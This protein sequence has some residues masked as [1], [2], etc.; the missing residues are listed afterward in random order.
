MNPA[1]ARVSALC[2][3]ACIWI[4]P[5]MLASPTVAQ[6]APGFP[7]QN[8]MP[9]IQIDPSAMSGRLQEEMQKCTGLEADAGPY[10]T[11][12]CKM[13][14]GIV[15]IAMGQHDA[16]F[17]T[18]RESASILEGEG[19]RFGSAVVYLM[20]GQTA[21]QAGRSDDA[22]TA[23]EKSISTLEEARESG[24]P[25]VLKFFAF[26]VRLSGV[27][28]PMPTDGPMAQMMG[29]MMLDQ[30]EL[31]VRTSLAPQ[32][33]AMGRLEEAKAQL[34]AALSVSRRHFGMMDGPVLGLL[35]Q[36]RERQGRIAEAIEMYDQ[37]IAA[38]RRVQNGS[39]Q[40]QLEA[41]RNALLEKANTPS[42]APPKQA[43]PDP[44]ASGGRVGLL[45]Q[46]QLPSG[47]EGLL[48]LDPN[49]VDEILVREGAR[50]GIARAPPD[51]GEC[52]LL[53]G[54]AKVGAG[55]LGSG[56]LDLQ[57]SVE[58]LDQA[59]DR[60]GSILIRSIIGSTQS[61][62]NVHAEA[63]AVYQEAISDLEALVASDE[64]LGLG[65]LTAFLRFAG[66]PEAAFPD[67]ANPRGR[68]ILLALVELV[69]RDGFSMVLARQ[70]RLEDAE[71]EIEKAAAMAASFS[72]LMDSQVYD[73]Y[74]QIVALRGRFEDARRHYTRALDG[75]SLFG[76]VE[77]RFEILRRLTELERVRGRPDEAIRFNQQALDLAMQRDRKEHVALAWVD[78]TNI[79]FDDGSMTDARSAARK[80]VEAAS[81][82]GN[83]MAR[84]QAQLAEALVATAV[85]DY[86]DALGHFE[87]TL[88]ILRG[89]DTDLPEI[90]L[91]EVVTL[92]LTGAVYG[93]LGRH[94]MI[95]EKADESRK[96]AEASGHEQAIAWSGLLQELG[97]RM[98][99]EPD[100]L[101]EGVQWHLDNLSR[102]SG[103]MHR[104]LADK[105]NLIA[106]LADLTELDARSLTAAR[107]WLDQQDGTEMPWER[108]VPVML[109]AAGELSR[110]RSSEAF[111]LLQNLADESSRSGMVELQ[112]M[113][114]S[115][116]AL[117]QW[118][119]GHPEAAATTA[120]ESAELLDQMAEN[121]QVYELL[122]AL[123]GEGRQ[124]FY[125]TAVSL[126][127]LN[128]QEEEAFLMAERAR[129]R[130]LLHM[131]DKQRFN[132]P[133][134][135]DGDLVEELEALRREILALERSSAPDQLLN[136]K[137][138]RYEE[139][140]V[141]I[142]LDAP[143]LAGLRSTWSVSLEIVQQDLLPPQ[144]TLLSFFLARHSVVAWVVDRDSLT[145]VVLPVSD[146]DL[147]KLSCLA[148]QVS[149]RPRGAT[150]VEPGCR[151]EEP[152][153]QSFFSKLLAPLMDEV[154]HEQLIV[155]PHGIL[156]YVP[157]AA[158]QNPETGQYL[159]ETHTVS[160]VP[161][162]GLLAI[163]A[164]KKSPFSG[165][166][167][168]MG[169]PGSDLKFVPEEVTGI[170]DLLGVKPF[171]REE[172]S[173]DRVFAAAGKIDLLHLA[174]HGRYVP[175]APRFSH[176]ALHPDGDDDGR[177]EVDEIFNSLDL[178]GVDLVALSACQTA[179][180]EQNDGDEIISLARAFIYAG[181]PAVVSTLWRV[182]DEA[183][184]FLMR[185]F[186]EHLISGQSYSE[187]LRTAQQDTLSHP[188]Q[189]EWSAPYYWA[190]FTLTG[191]GGGRWERS[192]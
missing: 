111:A 142:K 8:G 135:I 50:C 23:F 100:T 25:V 187:A 55:R 108:A 104:K 126:M 94:E 170:A 96:I 27:D 19:D 1:I 110:G 137:K 65:I 48:D 182:N 18:F 189:P 44:P 71:R 166:A 148:R 145:Q 156:H 149:R 146:E 153:A 52:R 60:V 9:Q 147:E 15:T 165:R 102:S 17:A 46:F 16:G 40:T 106:S 136:G 155:V 159:L 158:L 13:L 43:E 58:A 66:I 192:P 47:P 152:L 129:S 69:V 105:K 54:L 72:G 3:S 180:G 41:Q 42:A 64:V 181:T 163:L 92:G 83:F 114:T 82:S 176:I 2:I 36:L 119:S 70:D 167:L 88:T 115:V 132:V 62:A 164:E 134:D 57:A 68:A 77:L 73:H 6:T 125:Q 93:T 35:A 130:A 150:R 118:L 39:L 143:E 5:L 177:L 81:A 122:A 11:S 161:S 140:L 178:T 154:H 89:A 191:D 139:L 120:R 162:V 160:Y 63:L 131:L 24:G 85:A 20:M 141:R 10:E 124:G 91:M 12:S 30:M 37:A 80:A 173:E 26:F 74:A 157:F 31:A 109:L 112:A 123:F 183:T 188:D 113:T 49:Y 14:D 169:Y 87:K 22:V 67:P 128:D 101:R 185:R 95:A 171:L 38:A 90:K 117:M 7:M 144:T 190:G 174:A 86:D 121:V 103:L 34:Q 29:P 138:R 107:T 168:V 116:L 98:A 76:E 97:H 78:R 186:Y 99:G 61:Q 51:V 127:A 45:P 79:A 33:M 133:A 184:A 4:S 151:T 75:T 59:G 172:A 32:L 84:A 56:I 21:M 179:L 175:R 28:L 53:E